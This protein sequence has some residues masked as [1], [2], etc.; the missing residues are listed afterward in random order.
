MERI[1][2][3]AAGRLHIG[4]PEIY[5]DNQARKRSGHMTHAMIEYQPGRIIDFNSNCSAV[6][7]Y[8]HSAFGWIEYRYSDDYGEH[9][10]EIHDLPYSRQAFFDGNFT[11]SIEK[12]VCCNGV[13]TLFALRNTQFSPICCEPWLTVMVL[14]S[15]DF[16]KTWTE[17][18]ELCEFPGR[19]YDAVVRDG[20][21]YVMI[22]CN[23]NH[24]GTKPEHL[25]RLYR[26]CDDG[27]T[28]QLVGVID[29]ENI[30]HAY[31]ALQFRP[32]GALV[33]YSNN[34]KDMY[35]LSSS[36]SYDLGQSWERQPDVRL[37]EG[38][39]NIQI[40]QLGPGYVMHGRACRNSPWGKGFVVYTSK[41]AL[42]WDDGILLEPEKCS[43][44]YSNNLR[45]VRPDGAEKLLVQ[46]SD[47]YVDD[48]ANYKTVNVMHMFLHFE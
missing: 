43:C 31:G 22:F 23:E 40:S 11:V 12:G 2:D 27:R 41:D 29:I 16:G 24:V 39:R 17:P 38:I 37:S 46:Y 35:L 26:S 33:A 14:R 44:Y 36:V 28:F 5:V 4:E 34:I 30:D 7:S 1:F 48:P 3:G 8:G 42:H 10:S 47:I 15:S 18:V 32:D 9:W 21:I 25:Y 19:V 20:V 45:L 13:L 6:R